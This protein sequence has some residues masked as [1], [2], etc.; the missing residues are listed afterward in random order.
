MK[1]KKEECWRYKYKG[2]K[3]WRSETVGF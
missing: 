1:W 2:R 3:R